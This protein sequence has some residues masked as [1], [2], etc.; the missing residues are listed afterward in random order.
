MPRLTWHELRR[1]T[2]C[3]LLQQDRRSMEEVWKWLGHSSVLVTERAYAFLEEEQLQD[4]VIAENG[5]RGG[6]NPRA[7][8]IFLRA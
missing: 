3:R 4:V 1:T 5:R 7:P 8:A 6:S 2:G